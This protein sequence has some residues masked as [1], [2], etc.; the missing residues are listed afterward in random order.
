MDGSADIEPVGARVSVICS[1]RDEARHVRAALSG[2]LTPDVRELIV[3]DDGSTDETPRMLAAL[4]RDDVRVRVVTSP[5]V[6]RARAIDAALRASRGEFV[7]NLDA[8]DAIHPEWIRVGT[9]ILRH[10]PDLAVVAAAPRYVSGGET[11]AWQPLDYA[12]VVRDVTKWLAFYNPISHSSAIMRREALDAVNGYDPTRRTHVDYDL[13]IRLAAAG[14]RLGAVDAPL[15]AKRLHSGQK[16][17]LHQ[18]LRY[19]WASA[20]MQAH[21]IRAVRGGSAAWVILAGRLAWG[22]LP[23]AVRMSTRRLLAGRRRSRSVHPARCPLERPHPPVD[24]V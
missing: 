6:G 5:P 10:R 18:R 1:V 4:A 20:A 22:L 19:L 7:V 16:F 12:P 24:H 3:V 9:S 23:R 21:A 13:W 17:E 8:D 15:V 2:A 14:W 11:V